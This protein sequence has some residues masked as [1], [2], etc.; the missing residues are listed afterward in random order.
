MHDGNLSTIQFR[1]VS[2]G[3]TKNQ[4][5][6]DNCN[7]NVAI[8]PGSIISVIGPSGCG[9]T[10]FLRLILGL[11][12]SEGVQ[13]LP[14]DSAFGYVP[15]EPVILDHLSIAD[16]ARLLGEVGRQAG[17]FSEPRF[18][19]LTDM[20]G[21]RSI[22]SSNSSCLSLSGGEKQRL[23]LLRAFSVAPDFILLDEPCTGMDAVVKQRFLISLRELVDETKAIAVYVSHH[24]DEIQAVS[25]QVMF[26]E[27]STETNSIK[28]GICRPSAE[29]FQKPPTVLSAMLLFAP[30]ATVLPVHRVKQDIAFPSEAYYV[31]IRSSNLCASGKLE[32]SS[33]VK[34]VAL[35][36]D[37]KLFVANSNNVS[38]EK[39]TLKGEILLYDSMGNYCSTVMFE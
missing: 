32:V 17:R 27:Q 3:Y 29:F 23:M 28:N 37:S 31:L 4:L 8:R 10:T 11:E 2:F 25:N 16:N 35:E 18:Q 5:I 20:L 26:L 36:T 6:F 12:K 39:I 21:L 14:K 15:Q 13:V 38:G 33:E 22:L 1:S 24:S 19:K 30:F 34:I 7:L 9:K